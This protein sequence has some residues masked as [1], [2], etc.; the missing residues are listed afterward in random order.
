MTKLMCAS[1]PEKAA[2]VVVEQK[3]QYN[4]RGTSRLP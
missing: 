4:Y 2:R 1:T 3:N